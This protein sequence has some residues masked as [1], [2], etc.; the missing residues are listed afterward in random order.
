[1]ASVSLFFEKTQ[2]DRRFDSAL[3]PL[4]ARLRL[5]CTLKPISS[6]RCGCGVHLWSLQHDVR[7]RRKPNQAEQSR[8]TRKGSGLFNDTVR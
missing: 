8:S 2:E 7:T 5:V 1:M 6:M 4:K 3:A